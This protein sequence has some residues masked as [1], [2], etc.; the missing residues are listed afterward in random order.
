MAY[1]SADPCPA[2]R[3]RATTND[4]ECRACG[5]VW[6]E[7]HR[8]VHCAEIRATT[9][10]ATLGVVCRSCGLPRVSATW[11]MSEGRAT[12]LHQAVGRWRSRARA[13]NIAF[14][15]AVL[16][17]PLGLVAANAAGFGGWVLV[18]FAWVTCVVVA[19]LLRTS[20][21][22][23]LAGELAAAEREVQSRV[24]APSAERVRVELGGDRPTVDGQERELEDAPSPARL[25][26]RHVR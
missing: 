4:G 6:G 17:V 10:D 11:R 18:L 7:A 12:R 1:R 2:C 26:R 16:C 25:Y 9:E 20:G 8:C 22:R 21:K 15:L 13:A 24:E 3:S 5:H 23:R 14:T 19:S